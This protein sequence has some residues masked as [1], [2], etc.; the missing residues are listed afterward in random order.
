MY[1]CVHVYM[2]VWCVCT[3]CV[4]VCVV[5]VYTVCVCMM[6]VCVCTQALCSLT[7]RAVALRTGDELK[8]CRLEE[9]IITFC[10]PTGSMGV[11][12]HSWR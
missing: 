11:G 2:Y 1:V 6:C 5:C 3:P 7:L 10:L 12:E 4:Y 8:Q 9:N